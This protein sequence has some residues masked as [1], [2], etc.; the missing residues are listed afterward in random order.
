MFLLIELGQ[1]QGYL[2]V[3]QALC[4]K[5]PT[6]VFSLPPV[7]L[8]QGYIHQIVGKALRQQRFMWQSLQ[9]QVG[10]LDI[11][12]PKKCPSATCHWELITDYISLQ[13]PSSHP[14]T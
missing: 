12:G 2:T 11:P 13:A 3:L 6:P 8:R 10:V 1:F 14:V 5:G 9:T 7:L 4:T